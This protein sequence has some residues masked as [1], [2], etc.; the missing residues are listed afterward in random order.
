MSDIFVCHINCILLFLFYTT[1]KK[2]KKLILDYLFYILFYLNNHFHS[3]F[4]IVFIKREKELGESKRCEKKIIIMKYKA[5]HVKI[6][7]SLT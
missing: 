3:L 2:K 4:I 1:Y 5:N 7:L 6:Y